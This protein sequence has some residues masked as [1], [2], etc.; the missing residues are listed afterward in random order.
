MVDNN[1]IDTVII[2]NFIFYFVEEKKE[3]KTLVGGTKIEKR[4]D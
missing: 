1:S 3:K 4:G 2:I